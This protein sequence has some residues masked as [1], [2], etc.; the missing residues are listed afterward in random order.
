MLDSTT[1]DD[2]LITEALQH[3]AAHFVPLGS[4]SSSA[5]VTSRTHDPHQWHPRWRRVAL[6]EVEDLHV[7]VEGR[8]IL[9]GVNLTRSSRAR[10]TR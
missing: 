6:F 7:S 10:C 1:L 8:E 4:P 5:K 3:A 2:L 9:R